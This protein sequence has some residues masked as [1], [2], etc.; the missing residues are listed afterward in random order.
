V[1]PLE[2]WWMMSGMSKIMFLVLLCCRSWPLTHSLMSRQEGS[3]CDAGTITG[4][5]GQKVSNVF[6]ASQS[7]S[8]RSIGSCSGSADRSNTRIKKESD[9]TELTFKPLVVSPLQIPRSYVVRDSVS[10]HMTEGVLSAD[11]PSSATDNHSELCL[12]VQ[13]LCARK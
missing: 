10:K 8:H 2:S 7:V 9:H 13:C 5:S 1:K 11:I 4:P 12:V 3:S 6:P